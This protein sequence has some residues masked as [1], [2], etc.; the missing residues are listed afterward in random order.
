M[1]VH[2]S[3]RLVAVLAGLLALTYAGTAVAGSVATPAG[4][5][6]G[7]AR[8]FS[9]NAKFFLDNDR[10]GVVDTSFVFGETGSSILVGDFDGDDVDEIAVRRDISGAGKFFFNDDS[11][12]GPADASFVVGEI[13]AVPVVGDW[14]GDGD[15]NIGVRRDIGGDGKFFLDTN[16][17]PTIEINFVLGS[18]ADT[19]VVG[20]WDGNTTDNIGIVRTVSGGLRWFLSD[21]SGAVVSDFAFGTAGDT[22][23]VGDWDGDGDDNV[24]VVR[25]VG[26]VLRYFLDTN[27][28]TTPEIDFSF[29]QD[30][31]DTPFACAFSDV[32]MNDEVG[33][34]RAEGGG[35]LRWITT[36]DLD[37]LQTLRVRFG[38]NTDTP[39]VGE[40]E[41]PL[42]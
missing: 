6:W 2:S 15:D 36:A 4:C 7:V 1:I 39:F 37:G 30:A 40:F 26:G 41:P 35:A 9:G 19:P 12:P 33:I 23:I 42:F 11:D 10:D 17:T 22:P 29:G 31:T 21:D 16:G 18:T 38:N 25:N 5:S 27:G 28:D 34:A 3:S 8:D 20:N 24:G 13:A 32:T 14:D